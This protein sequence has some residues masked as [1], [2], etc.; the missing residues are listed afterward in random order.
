MAPAAWHSQAAA[1]RPAPCALVGCTAPSHSFHITVVARSGAGG[2]V[3]AALM[4]VAA[5]HP[6]HTVA[7]SER[8]IARSVV[9]GAGLMLGTGESKSRTMHGKFPDLRQHDGRFAA[10]SKTKRGVRT[11]LLTILALADTVAISVGLVAV[12]GLYLGDFGHERLVTFLALLLPTYYLLAV[13]QQAYRLHVV[14]NGPRSARRACFAFVFGVMTVISVTFVAKASDEL[15]RFLV[16]AGGATSCVLLAFARAMVARYA[17]AV[18]DGSP[19]NEVILIDDLPP[20][21][22]CRS[23]KVDVRQAGITPDVASPAMLDRL[24]EVVRDADRVI[25]SCSAERRVAWALALKG[26]GTQVEV[27]APEL[28]AIGAIRATHYHG[29]ATALVATGPLN[30]VDRAIKRAFDVVV[31]TLALSVLAI[32][33]LAVAVAIRLDSAGPVLFVQR[34]V[35][36]GNR[37]FAM[38][39]FRSMYADKTDHDAGKL[40]TRGD[41]RVTRIGRFIRTTSIDELPQL[42]NVLRGDMSI[43][44]PRPH[45]MGALAGDALYWEV[46]REY[47]SRHAVKPGL[48]GLA[49]VQGFR[50][51]TETGADLLNRLQADLAYLDSWTI[52]RD[53]T[54]VFKTTGV[55]LH[56]N[57]F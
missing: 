50:G 31:A 15:S 9:A 39:K 32:P 35:G 17:F 22:E 56:R 21:A 7:N 13:R 27:L 43:V 20:P 1:L 37:I 6:G 19:E 28:D 4:K 42:L 11:R 45:A 26:A 44:G 46:S 18:T 24:G 47:W 36:R 2:T 30:A 57:A 38:Y 14:I 12:A 29:T 3:T 41:S 33:M 52:W 40:A 51:N 23:F 25:V 55:V 16:L 5:R 54:L 53:I 10:V 49:Q 8:V 48:T 34:R